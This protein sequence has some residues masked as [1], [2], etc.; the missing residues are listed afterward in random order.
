MTTTIVQIADTVLATLPEVIAAHARKLAE[1]EWD[2][3]YDHPMFSLSCA[4]GPVYE[5]DTILVDGHQV[6][7][8]AVEKAL[9]DIFLEASTRKFITKLGEQIVAQAHQKAGQSQEEA[10]I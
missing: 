10:T 6:S 1:E 7:P 4:I 3:K 5:G 9:K 8:L 2:Q